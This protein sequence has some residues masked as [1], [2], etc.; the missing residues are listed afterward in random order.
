MGA[1]S[2]WH[3]L[4]LA[5][6]LLLLFGGRGKISDLMGDAAKG[7]RSFRKGLNEQ[8]EPIAIAGPGAT[9]TPTPDKDQVNA[10]H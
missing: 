8:D 10:E 9:Q 4:L 5:A 1:F 2:I 3:I 7:V 6:I